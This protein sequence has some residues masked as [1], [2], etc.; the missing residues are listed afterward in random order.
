MKCYLVRRYS[1][2]PSQLDWSQ[3]EV[4]SDF[5]SPWSLGEAQRTEFRA[6]WQGDHL[7]FRF[8]AWDDTPT[9]GLGETLKDRVLDSDRVEIFFAPDLTLSPYYCVEI[10]PSGE[11]LVYRG[12]F[13]RK[14]DWDWKLPELA[15]KAE[16]LAHGYEVTGRLSLSTLQQLGILTVDRQPMWVGLFRADFSRDASGELQR[17]W[18]PWVVPDTARPDFHVPGAFGRLRLED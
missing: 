1:G 16:R 6:F 15:V 18:M 11:A 14:M 9:L 8:E 13:Y 7:H 4:L 3:A 12:H 2:N 5:A 10:A 17:R